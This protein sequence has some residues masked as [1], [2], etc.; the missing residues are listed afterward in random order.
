MSLKLIPA[1]GKFGISRM[2]ER[3]SR[4]ISALAGVVTFSPAN[5]EGFWHHV[6]LVH[7]KCA[8]CLD[9][10]AGRSSSHRGEQR[11]YLTRVSGCR[12]LDGAVVAITYPSRD[13]EPL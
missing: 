12:Q 3:S 5:D 2:S 6:R 4:S 1:L 13:A 8:H 9:V 10:S 7:W 11:L